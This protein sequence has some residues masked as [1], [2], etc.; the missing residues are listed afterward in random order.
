MFTFT[1]HSALVV[2]IALAAFGGCAKPADATQI[3]VTV[4]SNF[5][6]PTHLDRIVVQSFSQ[7]GV[8][9]SNLPFQL[10]AASSGGTVGKFSLPLSFAVVPDN[11]D[12]SRHV[13]LDVAGF[14]GGSNV[15]V[16]DRKASLGFEEGRKIPLAIFLTEACGHVSCSSTQTCGNDGQC[17]PIEV[18]LQGAADGGVADAS[19]HDASASSAISYLT[20]PSQTFNEPSGDM[21]FARW[22]AVSADGST[23]AIS[24][25][26][27]PLYEAGNIYIYARN[28][29]DFA[30]TPSQTITPPTGVS[31]FA[32]GG[33][34]LSGGGNTL[35]VG[36][37]GGSMNAVLVFTRTSGSFAAAA[38]QTI[39][40][41]SGESD[42]GN[43]CAL[44]SD[45]ATLIV[46]SS[47]SVFVY[48]SSGGRFAADPDQSISAPAD[49]TG[50]FG[51]AVAMSGDGST[52]AVSDSNYNSVGIVYL[53]AKSSSAFSAS[54][55]GQ[56]PAPMDL[57]S[58]SG[59]FARA[60]ALR[61]D[62]NELVASAAFGS[63][64][65]IVY[66]RTSGDFTEGQRIR[67][68][69]SR[70]QFFGAG[71]AVS[72]DGQRLYVGDMENRAY[73]FHAN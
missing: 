64:M 60:L 63:R 12:S 36:S 19:T 52:I 71:I 14:V 31:T 28:G 26:R 42:F 34:A 38:T 10:E 41:P 37:F 54:P 29:G 66:S 55:T 58:S 8:V 27:T 22:V 21:S 46:T 43:A 25:A 51:E 24:D 9:Q 56:I 16:I 23:L 11:G 44:S 50:F 70:S 33:L 57:A 68:P 53:Y 1:R 39:D 18:S 62:G 67:S 30:T 2:L 49:A 20:T 35:A 32:V 13:Y 65:V 40:S 48:T 72:G 5:T 69:D 17:V 7:S 15:A 61:T 73:T 3:L 4:N 45:G 47:N 6:V 59:N